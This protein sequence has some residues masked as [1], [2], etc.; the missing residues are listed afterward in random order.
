MDLPREF[1]AKEA[2]TR[3]VRRELPERGGISKKEGEKVVEGERKKLPQKRQS[4]TIRHEFDTSSTQFD[5]K[6]RQ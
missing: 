4:D 6:R 5:P 3:K 2:A 1:P